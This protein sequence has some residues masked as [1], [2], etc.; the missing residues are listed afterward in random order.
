MGI[1]NIA[2]VTIT[3]NSRGV[4]RASFGIPCVIGS[5]TFNDASVAK[6]YELGK[7]LGSITTDST[8][9]SGDKT[10]RTLQALAAQT[11]KPQ[12]VIVGSAPSVVAQTFDITVIASDDG[13]YVLKLQRENATVRTFTYAASSETTTQIATGLAA[14]VNAD[15]GVSAAAVGPVI[16]VDLTTPALGYYE[17]VVDLDRTKL[18]YTD[19]TPVG[20]LVSEIQAVRAANSTWYGLNIARPAQEAAVALVAADVETK[21]ELFFHTSYDTAERTGA[22]IADNLGASGLQ[23]SVVVYSDEQTEEKAAAW[24]SYGFARDPGSITWAYKRV[25]LA[26]ADEFTS[27]EEAALEDDV[28]NRYYDLGGLSVFYPGKV[29]G[30]EWIDV[31]RGRDWLVVRLRERIAN[32]LIGSPKIPYTQAGAAAVG[33]AVEA[34]LREG[35]A[36]GYLSPDPLTGIDGDPPFVVTVPN[37]SEIDA[38]V[39]ATRVLPDVSFTAKLAGAIHQVQITGVIQV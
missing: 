22:G 8:V 38:A 14:L 9:V 33:N 21:E 35:I 28:C 2:Q 15:P 31:I 3:T 26:T 37:V 36:Q 5:F 4:D 34:Q 11:P 19:Q 25:A 29:A 18:S 23:R 39:K 32:L 10:Y 6:R 27:T 17:H 7:V 1:E 13:D 12:Y 24:M 16:T 20:S 30:D